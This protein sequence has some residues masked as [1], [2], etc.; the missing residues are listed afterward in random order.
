M[1]IRA[2]KKLAILNIIEI[3]GENELT[4]KQ[5]HERLSNGSRKKAELTFRQLTNVLS[6]Y[7]DKAGYDNKTK[8]IIWKKRD[9]QQ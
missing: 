2:G 1:K 6:S 8:C 9:D 7:F 5:I 4:T 3:I